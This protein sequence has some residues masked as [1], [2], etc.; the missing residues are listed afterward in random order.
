MY[1]LLHE[2]FIENKK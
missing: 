1:I 2:P